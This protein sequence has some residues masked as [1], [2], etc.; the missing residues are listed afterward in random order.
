MAPASLIS[1]KADADNES[2]EVVTKNDLSQQPRQKD[3]VKRNLYQL[4]LEKHDD[5]FPISMTCVPAPTS[6]AASVNEDNNNTTNTIVS[7]GGGTTEANH[8]TQQQPVG[9]SNGDDNTYGI[10]DEHKVVLEFDYEISLKDPQE[11][12]L[13]E[14]LE[15]DLPKLEYWILY[16]LAEQTGIQTCDIANQNVSLFRSTSSNGNNKLNAPKADVIGLSSLGT[17]HVDERTSK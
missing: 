3:E 10:G 1:W 4:V 5:F 17:D 16:Y 6:S 11:S 9:S 13:G 15:Q 14:V 8:Q 2:S 7:G 12:V